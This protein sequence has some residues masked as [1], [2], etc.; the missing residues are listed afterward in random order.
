MIT[1]PYPPKH[2]GEEDTKSL[3]TMQVPIRKA[4]MN[5]STHTIWEGGVGGTGSIPTR[6]L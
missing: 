3:S 5:P 2:R 6:Y 1:V 4:A